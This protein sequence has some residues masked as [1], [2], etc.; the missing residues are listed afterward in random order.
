MK[1]QDVDLKEWNKDLDDEAAISKKDPQS[2]VQDTLP[3]FADALGTKFILIQMM[4]Y[5]APALKSKDW[6]E[7]YG[8]LIAI[9]QVSEG[10]CK[11]FA[12]DLDNLLA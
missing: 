4:P 7:Q 10:S 2:C 1:V 12:N 8:G 5:I 6:R 9:S 3:K 11:H